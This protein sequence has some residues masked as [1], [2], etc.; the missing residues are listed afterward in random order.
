[1]ERSMRNRVVA[2]ALSSMLLGGLSGC[3]ASGADDGNAPVAIPRQGTIRV[4]NVMPDAGRMTSFLSSSVYGANQFGESTALSQNL[5]GQY[6]MNIL[7]TPPNDVSTTLVNNEPTDLSDQ[8]EFSFIMIGPVASPQ[9]VR[10]N[11]IEISFGVDPNKPAQF[12]QPDYQILHASTSTGTVDVYV[13]EASA[14]L[15]AASPAATLSFSQLTSLT[16]LDS[17]LSYRVRVTGTGTKTVLFDSGSF[18]VARFQRS[19]YLLLDNFGPT[20]ESL[21]VA[22]LT[23]LGAENFPNQTMQGALRFANMIPD[24]PLVDVYLG[25]PAGTPLFQNVAYGDTTAYSLAVT[26]GSF[27]ANVTPAGQPGTII[28][29]GTTAVVGGE[30]RSIYA[31]GLDASDTAAAGTV[32]DSQR[33]VSGQAQFRFVQTAPSA[34]TVDVYLTSPG[35]P[36]SDASPIL[37]NGALLSSSSVN[38]TPASYDLFVTRS[39]TTV[40]LFGPD[41]ISVS[42]GGVYTGV[43]L[44]AAGG[45]GPLQMQFT[46]EVLP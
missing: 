23:A 7:L 30:A 15:D 33:S 28:A 45:G 9:L 21:R 4:A 27:T 35:R 37:A 16:Q 39:G 11:N 42:A 20:G 3:G 14:D 32:V 8:D 5:V 13:T 12:P 25:T 44:D 31:S 43:L 34:G 6:V 26:N 46:P 41:R 22:N 29:T 38:L 17:A 40:Q 10:I 18:A 1:M 24:A 2:M 19:I 36:I